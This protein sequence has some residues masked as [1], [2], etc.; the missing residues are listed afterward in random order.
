MTRMISLLTAFTLIGMAACATAADK[1]ALSIL[2]PSE[3]GVDYAIQGE[4]VGDVVLP[5]QEEKTIGAQV[6]AQG[7]G[8]FVVV[9]YDGGLP[10]DGWS[11]GDRR[12]HLAGE[13]KDGSVALTGEEL[14]GTIAD[15]A[16]LLG[17]VEGDARVQINKTER[18]STT[19]GAKPPEGATVIFDG[20]NTDGFAHG[21]LTDDNHLAAGATTAA[22]FNNYTLHLEFFLPFMPNSRGQG[23]SNSGVYLHDCYELQVLDSFGLEGE[24]NECGGFYKVRVPDV[25][26]CLPPLVW[27]TFDI[28][29]TAPAYN[30]EG[31][32]TAPARV[33]VRHNGVVIHPNIELSETPGRQEEGPGPRP[34]HFQHH[35][36][37][38]RYRNIWV[39]E[40]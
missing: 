25:N 6:I 36:N 32:K 26:M 38:V 33:T 7:G 40:K 23:R 27:Q 18:K 4:Y 13:L 34:I 30:A 3:A 9:V 11:R 19:V 5:S 1:N 2:D 15:G 37:Q 24:N 10:G 31:A 16:M 21:D 17:L 12:F 8:K 20:S 35:G 29:F 28:D 39:V 22:K 14:V